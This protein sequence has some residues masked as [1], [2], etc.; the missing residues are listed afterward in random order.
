MADN[1]T[2]SVAHSACRD[3]IWEIHQ[4]AKNERDTSGR[5]KKPRTAEQML[6]RVRRE[7]QRMITTA[8]TQRRGGDSELWQA[9][10]EHEWVVVRKG[11]VTARILEAGFCNTPAQNANA[12]AEPMQQ[13]HT[14]QHAIYPAHDFYPAQA[15]FEWHIYVD[16]S[17]EGEGYD[18]QKDE[19]DGPPP[20]AGVGCAELRRRLRAEE[21]QT[22]ATPNLRS[23][24][25]FPL[26]IP[27]EQIV[28][29]FRVQQETETAEYTWVKADMVQ[30]DPAADDFLGAAA[31]TNNTAELSALYHALRRALSR[32]E[33]NEN[34]T[35]YTDSLY[36]KNMATGK[37]MPKKKHRN[38]EQIRNIRSLWR[39]VQRARQNR[40]R[41]VHVRSHTKIPGNELADWLADRGAKERPT[42]HMDKTSTSLWSAMTWT[43]EWLQK[44]LEEARPG[45]PRT[46]NARPPGHRHERPRGER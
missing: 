16:G 8:W 32:K 12:Q 35:I 19:S 28:Q 25:E 36:A 37:W 14:K 30:D 17:W 1:Q 13:T 11:N 26:R 27:L 10:R 15:E 6:T 21:L 29:G 41:I 22:E 34:E 4:T 40:V 5:S 24:Y 45:G 43:R 18:G 33:R 2:N 20:P 23:R 3:K 38:S 44:T 46:D 42:K 31:H 9:W 39:K 7:V